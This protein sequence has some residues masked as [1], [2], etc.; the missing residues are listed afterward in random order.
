MQVLRAVVKETNQRLQKSDEESEAL[1]KALNEE[2]ERYS[3]LEESV[4]RLESGAP[5]KMGIGGALAALIG[6]C[7]EGLKKPKQSE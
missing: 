1:R 5:P 4:Q 2:R 7:F 6:A 3:R